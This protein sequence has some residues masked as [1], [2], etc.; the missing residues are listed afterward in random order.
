MYETGHSL[1]VKIILGLRIVTH[2]ILVHFM[3]LIRIIYYYYYYY[4]YNCYYVLNNF[5]SLLPRITHLFIFSLINVIPGI[6]VLLSG[7]TEGVLT[8]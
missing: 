1:Y 4:H 6:V 8:P 3:Y 2:V 7:K 5:Y